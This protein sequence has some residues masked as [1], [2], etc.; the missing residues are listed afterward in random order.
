MRILKKEVWPYKVNLKEPESSVSITE[1]ELWL[2]KQFGTFKGRWNIVYQ[3]K[4]THF[5]FKT[6]SDA[7]LFSLK[8]A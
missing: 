8:W 4:E 7:V 3:H 6:Q 5:Y 2:G 1:M